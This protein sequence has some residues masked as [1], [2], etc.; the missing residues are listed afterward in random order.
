MNGRKAFP[1]SIT[2]L[3]D[4][5]GLTHGLMVNAAEPRHLDDEMTL[6]FSSNIPQELETE[7]E[8]KVAKGVVVSPEELKSKYSPNSSDVES[9]QAWL[10][11]QGFEIVRLSSDN[12]GVYARA[13]VEKIQD[14]LGVQMVRVTRDG[15][16]YNAARNAPSLPADVGKSVHAIIGLQPFRRANK[17]FRMRLPRAGNRL[18]LSANR[19][20]IRGPS[21]N[22]ANSPPYLVREVL[23][24]YNADN[25]AV[26]GKGQ[27][28]AI[29]IDTFPLD[30]DLMAFWAQ[31]DIRATLA[32]IEKINVNGSVLSPPEGEET[33]DAEWASGIAPGAQIRIYASGS[34]EFV[35]LDMALDQIFSDLTSQPGMRQLSISLGLGERFLGGP[36]GEVAT[37]HQKFLRLAAAGVNVFVSSG[38]AGSNP[39]QTGHSSSGPTQAEYEASDPFVV[40]VGGTSLTLASDGTVSSESGWS[41]SGGGKS[42][43]FGRP[44]WQTGNGVPPGNERL[45]PDVSLTA[46]PDEGAFLVLNG[47]VIQIGG[48]SWSAPV[49]AGFCA[50]IN[51]AR[52]IAGKP[53]LSF[54]NPLLYPLMGS[55]CFR[56]IKTGTN[57]AFTA[58]PGYDLVSGIGVPNVKE[59]IQTLTQ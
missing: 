24:A 16:T 28:I 48:T 34:L 56:D 33:L 12:T 4:Q 46:N 30:T 22:I 45:V 31:N 3:P 10:K 6:L 52:T 43:F 11:K 19:V 9:L 2:P 55:S 47:R 50:L 35:D 29:L 15:L 51:E 17:H 57:G 14:S 25:L 40:G 8:E 23:K 5:L 27:T 7:L 59:L 36:Q 21:K 39:D 38:D 41:S 49:W 18:E 20:A 37:Q 54:L 53:A 1:D 26:S 32:Q 44:Q 42:I 13:S 58:G